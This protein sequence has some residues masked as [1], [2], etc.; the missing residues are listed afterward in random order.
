MR[1]RDTPSTNSPESPQDDSL[2]VV[3]HCLDSMRDGDQT[4]AD[5]A[6]LQSLLNEAIGVSV[7]LRR[8]FV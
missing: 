2:V 8:G 4:A 6:L 5:E 1:S 3:N 7:N